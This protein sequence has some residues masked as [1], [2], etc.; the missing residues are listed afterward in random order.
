MN[1]DHSNTDIQSTGLVHPCTH[2]TSTL[3]SGGG[4]TLMSGVGG[5]L[6]SHPI[7]NTVIV[8]KSGH[9]VQLIQLIHRE[10][11]TIVKTCVY[12]IG[13]VPVHR[14]SELTNDSRFEVCAMVQWFIV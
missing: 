7:A 12:Y 9:G 2:P 5:Y 6:D 8:A 13:R 4:Y 10:V 11:G 1:E 14:G 3:M